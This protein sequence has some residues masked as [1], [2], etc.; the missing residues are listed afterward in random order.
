MMISDFAD[1]A[2][3]IDVNMASAHLPLFLDG[4]W[5]A[6][7][8][9][10]RCVDGTF[11]LRSDSGTRRVLL[12]GGANAVRLDS[13]LDAR[14]RQRYRRREDFVRLASRDGVAEMMEWGMA[15]VRE[16]EESG[17]LAELEPYRR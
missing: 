12:P 17:A 16:M 11:S 4:R 5:T 6:S 15:Y 2:E 10:M 13:A 9:G 8:R 14:M 3:L 1:R 7:V